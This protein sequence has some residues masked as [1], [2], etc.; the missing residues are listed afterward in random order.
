MSDKVFTLEVLPARKGDCLLLH[1]GAKKKPGFAIIDGGPA[2]VYGPHLK[3]RLLQ[4]RAE[5]KIPDTKP[6]V[7]DFVMLSHIDDDHVKGLLQL[8]DELVAAERTRSFQYLK[9]RRLWHNSFDDIVGNT[10]KELMAAATASFGT[11]S[12]TGSLSAEVPDDALVDADTFV[13]GIM[14]LA[15][16]EQGFRLRDDA[17]V[18]KIPVNAD[19]KGG[20]VIAVE[21][22]A[23]IDVGNGLTFTVIGPMRTEVEKLQQKHDEWLAKQ[24]QKPASNTAALAE[25]VDRSVPNLSSL[26]L[27]AE[28][29]GKTV[30]FTGD[31]RGDKILEGLQLVGLGTELHVNVL[32]VPHHGSANNV[33]ADFFARV[34]AE[35]YVFSGNGEHGN[36]ERETFEMLRTARGGDDY[37]IHL[38][39]PLDQI[40]TARKAEWD[41][42]RAA[43]I[44]GGK[45]PRPAWS[46]EKH[47]LTAF[48]GGDP[49]MAAK[50]VPLEGNP[51]HT[52]DLLGAR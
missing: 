16:V 19:G 47:S 21:N 30:L 25:Y 26:V 35:H 44:T 48:F 23:P 29:E 33:E 5:K 37:R 34:T 9:A 7:A 46:Q 13:A 2:G 32:K 12:A 20:L 15:G 8:T 38:T 27:L 51:A 41:K 3:P 49:E 18:L 6:L 36:P 11:A 10:A 42:K 52:I 39:Y 31:A 4:L 50:I 45:K 28:V 22:G 43:E 17:Q 24:Q 40:D 1:Y 14:V